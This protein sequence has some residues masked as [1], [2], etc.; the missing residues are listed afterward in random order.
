MEAFHFATT[1][2]LSELAVHVKM[3]AVSPSFAG[4]GRGR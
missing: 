3:Y 1:T 2:D 4:R